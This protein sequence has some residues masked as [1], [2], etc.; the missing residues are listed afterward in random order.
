MTMWL[1]AVWRKEWNDPPVT[2]AAAMVPAI[3][4]MALLGPRPRLRHV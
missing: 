2:R 3:C 1:A 4:T